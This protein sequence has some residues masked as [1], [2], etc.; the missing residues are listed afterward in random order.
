PN[1]LDIIKYKILN[2]KSKA[3]N[4]R[5]VNLENGGKV[6]LSNFCRKNNISVNN[7]KIKELYDSGFRSEKILIEKYREV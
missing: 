3:A 1:N 4:Y 2:K 5:Y 6:G 7:D